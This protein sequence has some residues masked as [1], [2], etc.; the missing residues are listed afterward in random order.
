MVVGDVI[1]T[2]VVAG[3]SGSRFG[4][5]KQFEAFGRSTVIGES[6]SVA[7]TVSDG[8]IAVVPAGSLDRYDGADEVV[9]GGATRA[10]SV[11]AG[12]AA[13]PDDASI[14]LV[15]DAARPLATVALYERVVSAVRLG[16]DAAVPVISVTDTLRTRDGAAV[17]RDEYVAVQTPQGFSAGSLRAAH[18]NEPEASDDASLVGVAGGTV[19]AVEGDRWNLKL[20]EPSDVVVAVA[21]WNAKMGQ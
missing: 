2:I 18:R 7:K 11:R 13:V 17:D 15:H 1:W 9:A 12:L 6:I 21:L 14:I 4:T 19:V 16:A 5:R 10:A 8:V 20:T 3:G